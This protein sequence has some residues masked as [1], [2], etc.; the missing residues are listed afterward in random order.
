MSP[1]ETRPSAEQSSLLDKI[2]ARADVASEKVQQR[3]KEKYIPELTE[4]SQTGEGAVRKI[5]QRMQGDFYALVEDPE[6]ERFG[7]YY[8][9]WTPDEIRELFFVIYGEDM[10][11]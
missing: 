5:L 11:E 8:E 4:M 3:M 1:F 7:G 9:G 6:D 10:E 2:G